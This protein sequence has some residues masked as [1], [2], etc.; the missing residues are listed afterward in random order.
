M[1]KPSHDQP[2]WVKRLPIPLSDDACLLEQ[3]I[4]LFPG[5]LYKLGDQMC[6]GFYTGDDF[7]IVSVQIIR[8]GPVLYA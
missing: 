4:E 6:R 8:E 1:V 7:C 5:N 3:I 2:T